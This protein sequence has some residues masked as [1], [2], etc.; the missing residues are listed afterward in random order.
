M[1]Q[2]I[3][4]RDIVHDLSESVNGNPFYSPSLEIDGCLLEGLTI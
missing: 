2:Y 4:V 3:D 1:I